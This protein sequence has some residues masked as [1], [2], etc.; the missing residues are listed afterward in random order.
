MIMAEIDEENFVDEVYEEK[1]EDT[2]YDGFDSVK[3]YKRDIGKVKLLTKEEEVYLF[4]QYEAGD[5]EAFKR[6][7]AANGRWV[8]RIAS[9]SYRQNPSFEY[10]D[11]VGYGNL[12]LMK[13]IEKFDYRKGYKFSTYATW[14]I[15]QSIDRSVIGEGRKIRVPNHMVLFINKINRVKREFYI[16]NGREPEIEEIAV[17]LGKTPEYISDA[18]SHSEDAGSLNIYINSDDNSDDE[19]GDFVAD[20]KVNVEDSIIYDDMK[21][22]I[23]EVFAISSLTDREK[24]VLYYRFGFYNNRTYTLEEVGTIFNVTRERIRQIETKALRKLRHPKYKKFLVDFIDLHKKSEEKKTDEK[25]KVI[26]KKKKEKKKSVCLATSLFAYL[27]IGEEQKD[28]FYDC[29]FCFNDENL[30]LL[31]KK[32]GKNYDG[33]GGSKVSEEESYRLYYFLLPRLKDGIDQLLK[34]DQDSTMYDEILIKLTQ[35]FNENIVLNTSFDK[36]WKKPNEKKLKDNQTSFSSEIKTPELNMFP[37][38]SAVNDLSVAPD[39][40]KTKNGVGNDEKNIV[41]K[42]RGR[43]L[44]IK[45]LLKYFN[46]DFTL[47]ELKQ[48]ID[49]LSKEEAELMYLACGENLDGEQINDSSKED[50]I[51]INAIIMPK[52]KLRLHQLY[53][54]RNEKVNQ[55]IANK[56]GKEEVRKQLKQERHKNQIENTGSLQN[57]T[58]KAKKLPIRKK[59]YVFKNLLAYFDYAYAFEELKC[60]IDSL[61]LKEKKAIYAFCG[62]KLDG[63]SLVEVSVEV[64]KVIASS[65]LPKLKRKL[66]HFYPGRNEKVDSF[67]RKQNEASANYIKK[68]NQANSIL[69]GNLNVQS[70]ETGAVQRKRACKN[71][72]AYFDYAY[73]FEE[74]QNAIVLL[75]PNDRILVYQF[76]GPMLDGNSSFIISSHDRKNFYGCVAKIKFKLYKLYPGRLDW[77]D[78]AVVASYNRMKKS[79]EIRLGKIREN[80]NLS[81]L[82]EHNIVQPMEPKKN[83]VFGKQDYIRLA[84]LFRFGTFKEMIEMDFTKE[85]AFIIHL[86][87]FGKDN[88][89]YTSLE[90][91]QILGISEKTVIDLAR[92]SVNK[93]N[94]IIHQS[95]DEQKKMLLKELEM[96]RNV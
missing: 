7:A 44:L 74:L 28:I 18:L 5:Q 15:K 80:G 76:C 21:T 73:T 3:L 70:K 78:R 39:I 6:I 89:S 90:V 68:V 55:F 64:R 16:L 49:S 94:N 30:E 27:H 41:K 13:A 12:G 82:D 66:Y 84:E 20:G 45:N 10:L 26:S 65:Y 81:H 19:L 29:I 85:E 87:H 40:T 43:P 91:A 77:L 95:L 47:E 93:Y 71:L 37:S 88:V 83:L 96:R 53:P 42:R 57:R 46:Y 75:E 79:K 24:E 8:M 52:I 62:E 72:L 38:A 17:I 9:Q 14:W 22:R 35:I 4:Q 69:N 2:D 31:T 58:I 51:Q 63:N 56:N 54:R 92:E 48:V 32:Y 34:V 50:R 23:K 67:V 61:T 33:I 60:M 59:E 86:L 11:L 25:K 1:I 36:S